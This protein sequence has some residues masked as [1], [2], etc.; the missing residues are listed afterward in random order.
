MLRLQAQFRGLLF[1]EEP[2]KQQP[3]LWVFP[4]ATLWL[5]SQTTTP[6]GVILQT[7]FYAYSTP[8]RTFYDAMRLHP[9]DRRSQQ[10]FFA[11]AEF[12]THQNHTSRPRCDVGRCTASQHCVRYSRP[13]AG[14]KDVDHFKRGTSLFTFA[15]GLAV[16][17][18]PA[19]S[20]SHNQF[21]RLHFL[22]SFL[23]SCARKRDVLF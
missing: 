9:R 5:S 13:L 15:A 4:L 8:Y 21:R 20:T 3:R 11:I 23:L 14:S 12:S 1:W 19:A 2:L 10:Q 17:Y 18:A 6:R 7:L 16:Y 22:G